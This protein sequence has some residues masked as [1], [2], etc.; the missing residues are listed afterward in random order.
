[1]GHRNVASRGD[2]KRVNPCI[3]QCGGSSEVV[4]LDSMVDAQSREINT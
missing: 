1:V 3:G 4:K 2:S